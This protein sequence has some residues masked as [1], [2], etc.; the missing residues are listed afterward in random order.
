MVGISVKNEDKLSKSTIHKIC[1]ENIHKIQSDIAEYDFC[2][3]EEVYPHHP[4]IFK[5]GMMPKILLILKLYDFIDF[6]FSLKELS[7][8]LQTGDSTK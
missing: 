1:Q 5:E 4:D 8:T 7:R 3:D 6:E 2:Y